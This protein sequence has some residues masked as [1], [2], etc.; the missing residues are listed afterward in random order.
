MFRRFYHAVINRVL[1]P[2]ENRFLK[3]LAWQAGAS[4]HTKIAQRHL[5]HYYRNLALSDSA[6]RPCG[7]QVF[8]VSLSS[9][10]MASCFSYLPC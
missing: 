3:R 6:P 8:A 1:N 2:L 5:Y 10:K 9:K 7:K 4:A